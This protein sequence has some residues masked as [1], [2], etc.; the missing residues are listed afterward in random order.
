[1][2]NENFAVNNNSD[3][4]KKLAFMCSECNTITVITFNIPDVQII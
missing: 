3:E 1:M 2:N 4:H